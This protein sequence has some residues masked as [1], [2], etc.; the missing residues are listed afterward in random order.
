MSEVRKSSRYSGREEGIVVYWKSRGGE[1]FSRECFFIIFCRGIFPVFQQRRGRCPPR[2]DANALQ[3]VGRPRRRH[4]G[5]GS[6]RLAG[7]A[8]VVPRVSPYVVTR[9]PLLSA[10]FH[11][12]L[13]VHTRA[14]DGFKAK[15]PL[16][17]VRFSSHPSEHKGFREQISHNE[18]K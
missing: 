5:P 9:A 4:R 7:S 12:K 3:E 18:R 17:R 14:N 1:A 11:P 8:Y 13:V 16:R 6:R 10:P 2:L 15:R